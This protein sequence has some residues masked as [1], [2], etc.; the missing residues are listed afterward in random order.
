[1]EPTEA[2]IHRIEEARRLIAV[3]AAALNSDMELAADVAL[4]L[5]RQ[6]DE[7]LTDAAAGLQ[8][9]ATGCVQA[10]TGEKV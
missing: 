1:M 5:Q 3:C 6:I 9:S 8:P 10:T 2:A 4:I 7:E